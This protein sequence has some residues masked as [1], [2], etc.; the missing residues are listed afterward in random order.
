[1]GDTALPVHGEHRARGRDQTR[2]VK[3]VH[4]YPL[5]PATPLAGEDHEVGGKLPEDGG[6]KVGWSQTASKTS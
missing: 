3:I 6:T 4:Q 5:Q 1:M 2:D